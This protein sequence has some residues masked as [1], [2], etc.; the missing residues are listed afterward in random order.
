M[1]A[2]A[3]RLVRLGGRVVEAAD[4]HEGVI[5]CGRAAPDEALRS[6]RG[7]ATHHADR[8]QH[9][10]RVGMGQEDRHRAERAAGE[11]QVEAAG[12]DMAAAVAEREGD[13]HEL[14]IEELALLDP[15]HVGIA[16]AGEGEDPGR[17]LRIDQHGRVAGLGAAL[18]ELARCSIVDLGANQEDPAARDLGPAQEPEQLIGLAG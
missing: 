2:M 3:A 8:G 11:V 16:L 15:D 13:V 17:F 18:G 5:D 1:V 7:V 4:D 12:N 9:R 14:G 6:C 10:D